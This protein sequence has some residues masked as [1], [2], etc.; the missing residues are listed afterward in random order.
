MD[1]WR[2]ST[3]RDDTIIVLAKYLTPERTS[4]KNYQNYSGFL[5]AYNFVWLILVSEHS[6]YRHTLWSLLLFSG[7][8]LLL[9]FAIL[10]D[11]IFRQ[12]YSREQNH[13]PDG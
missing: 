11:K 7:V 3:A 5:W 10:R 9:L 8:F 4:G 13:R 6:S 2:G 12:L 1:E